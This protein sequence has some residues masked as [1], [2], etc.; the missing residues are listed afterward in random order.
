MFATIEDTKYIVQGMRTRKVNL[1]LA[2]CSNI[3]FIEHYLL[4]RIF[5][6]V[7][8]KVLEQ[9]AIMLMLT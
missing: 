5:N 8:F 2:I 3:E 9:E 1:V 6:M 7:S 4:S